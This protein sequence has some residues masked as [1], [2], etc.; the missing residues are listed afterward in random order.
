[1][2][3]VWH[4]KL[5]NIG[6]YADTHIVHCTNSGC[7]QNRFQ[8]VVSIFK[9]FPAVSNY[10]LDLS[11]EAI[12]ILIF[13]SS[14][15]VLLCCICVPKCC[16]SVLKYFSVEEKSNSQIVRSHE[17]VLCSC[18]FMCVCVAYKYIGDIKSYGEPLLHA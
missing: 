18:S 2:R 16:A 9:Q 6:Q 17:F 12:A 11:V 1:M 15:G 5:E 13:I 7:I 8:R 10:K 3:S 14:N 4:N